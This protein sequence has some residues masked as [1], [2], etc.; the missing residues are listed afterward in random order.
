MPTNIPILNQNGVF[1]RQTRLDTRFHI[2]SSDLFTMK[3]GNAPIMDLGMVGLFANQG[4]LPK[5]VG[6]FNIRP[7]R[8][9]SPTNEFKWSHPTSAPEWRLLEDLSFDQE[10][11]RAGAKFRLK[12]NSRR[13]DNGWVIT[14]DPQISAH[15]VVTP[16]EIVGNPADGYIYT[17]QLKSFGS[18]DK[19]FPKDLLRPGNSWYG[20]ST[21]DSEYNQVY[22]SV[23]E[24]STG[25]REFMGVVGCTGSQIQYSVTEKA[26]R[27][28]IGKDKQLAY[29]QYLDVIESFMFKPGTLGYDFS[30]LSPEEKQQIDITNMYQRSYGRSAETRMG[31]DTILSGWVPKVEAIATA[32]M[33]QMVETEAFYGSGGLVDYDGKTKAQSI[34]GLFHQLMLGNTHDFNPQFL[35]L[36][37][38]EAAMTSALEGK[39]DYSPYQEPVTIEIRTGRGGLGLI[40]N[41]LDRLPANHGLF[42]TTDNIIEGLGGNNSTLFF[43]TP[44]FTHYKMRNNMAILK[45]VYEPSLDPATANDQINPF[46]PL[47]NGVG[48]NRLSSYMF[49]VEDLSGNT[50]EGN[51]LE[52]MY[53]KDFGIKK[54]VEQGRLAYPGMSNG[55]V[56]MGITSNPGFSVQFL[57]NHKGYHL[58]DPTKSLIMRPINPNTGKPIFNY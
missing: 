31:D 58:L 4:F 28:T 54:F 8:V 2:D 35:T 20:L 11:G 41:L 17:V 34:L 22:S 9:Y 19:G 26:S 38:F 50:E 47:N 43:N 51:V 12:F 48:G 7:R 14:P 30:R 10:P 25:K 45:F 57:Q 37:R 36:E 52:I 21:V 49:I 23:P 33:G 5:S 15:L 40:Q 56:H 53:E 29:D 46:L 27:G 1:L 44:R 32:L 13:Y 42:W 6:S 24:F 3:N 55:G 18:N 39:I 16:D